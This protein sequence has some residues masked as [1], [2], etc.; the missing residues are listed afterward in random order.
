VKI[1]LI[2]VN[3]KR[4]LSFEF[5]ETCYNFFSDKNHK[6]DVN[7]NTNLSIK[8]VEEFEDLSLKEPIFNK[9]YNLLNKKK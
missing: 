9:K 1:F 4:S 3:V 6:I 2:K 7:L 8:N 5:N